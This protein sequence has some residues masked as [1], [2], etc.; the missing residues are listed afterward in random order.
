MLICVLLFASIYVGRGFLLA[1][2][3][4]GRYLWSSACVDFTAMSVVI[5]A[6]RLL[7][8]GV[9]AVT[10]RV[11]GDKT[12]ARKRWAVVTNW[13]IVFA[14]AGPFLIALVQFHPQRIAC[15][16]TPAQWGMPYTDVTLQSDGLRLA[17]WHIPASSPDRPVVLIAH[18][19][20]VNKQNFLPAARIVHELDY[21]AF[22]FDFRGHGDSEGR[23]ITFGVK[24]SDD[25]RAAYEYLAQQ[26]P[27]SRKYG[28]GHSMGGTA[29]ARMASEDMV[30]D[31]VVLDSTFSRSE[32]AARESL[33][34]YFGPLQTPVWHVGRFW[35]W[36]FTGV[37]VEQH[38]PER[39]VEKLASRP[40]LLIH[41]TADAMIP[42]SECKR[43][44]EAAG[45][46]SQLWLVD[47]A[48]HLE[49]MQHP[50]YKERLRRFF[51]EKP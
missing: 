46:R 40:L 1:R 26:H 33:L 5:L 18:G 14:I 27:M 16:S 6:F 28:L 39:Y 15:N 31:K 43:L 25:V 11:I 32:T 22:I 48:G 35:G 24:E 3:T 34:W 2:L 9:K 13:A 7:D 12:P 4:D 23:T 10:H 51:E 47:N 8:L 17:G 41:G 29:L 37:D 20:G 42:V 19:V 49:T 21:N 45:P 44:H 36:V 30:F 50:D 38:Q